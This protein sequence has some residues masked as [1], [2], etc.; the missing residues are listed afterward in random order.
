MKKTIEQKLEQLCSLEKEIKHLQLLEE[1]LVPPCLRH[2]TFAEQSAQ[3]SLTKTQLDNALIQEVKK[4]DHY[5]IIF[6]LSLYVICTWCSY[7]YSM[8]PKLR[9]G[10]IR[11][12]EDNPS[13]FQMITKILGC[14]RLRHRLYNEKDHILAHIR[15]E[16]LVYCEKEA[17]SFIWLK[18]FKCGLKSPIVEFQD[19]RLGKLSFNSLTFDLCAPHQKFELEGQSIYPSYLVSLRYSRK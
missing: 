16:P 1:Q 8:D 3:I 10:L 2:F 9:K 4:N 19:A 17:S 13:Q 12:V 18:F 11:T 6:C 15:G 5:K 14:C 7:D